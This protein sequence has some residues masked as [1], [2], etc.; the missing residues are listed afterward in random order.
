MCHTSEGRDKRSV[1]PLVT[2]LGETFFLELGF[3]V[4]SE[5]FFLSGT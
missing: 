2:V 5:G 1:T 4:L 3:R